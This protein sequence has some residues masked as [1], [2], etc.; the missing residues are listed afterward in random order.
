MEERGEKR[1]ERGEER[2]DERGEG[3]TRRRGHHHLLF[4]LLSP[5]SPVG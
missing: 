1:E 5:Q 2:R 3:R 4:S